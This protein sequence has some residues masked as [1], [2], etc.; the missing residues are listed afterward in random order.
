MTPEN[1]LSEH[2]HSKSLKIRVI[3]G[4][5][6]GLALMGL[7]LAGVESD[8]AWGTYWKL[9]PFLIVPVAGA[10]GGAFLYF[11]EKSGSEGGWKKILCTFLGLLGY[12]LALW[13][14]TV[15]GLDGTL[16]D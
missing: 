16:W 3:G 15:L 11:L 13:L 5:V 10:M 14:G 7:F 12:V 1:N 9:R 6:I 4:A 2:L 8:P